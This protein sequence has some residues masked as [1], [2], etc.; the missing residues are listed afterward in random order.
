MKVA[1]LASLVGVQHDLLLVGRAVPRDVPR[2]WMEADPS[3]SVVNP[4]PLVMDPASLLRCCLPLAAPAA[5]GGG[6]ESWLV[7]VMD[8]PLEPELEMSPLGGSA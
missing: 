4:A 1:G 6:D 5:D 8:G 3:F 7:T 2:V